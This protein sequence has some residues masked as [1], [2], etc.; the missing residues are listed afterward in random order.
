MFLLISNRTRRTSR[1]LQLVFPDCPKHSSLTGPGPE[2]WVKNLE[3][4]KFMSSEKILGSLPQVPVL[5]G[6]ATIHEKTDRP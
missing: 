2:I 3:S 6:H 4:G 1:G 5:P